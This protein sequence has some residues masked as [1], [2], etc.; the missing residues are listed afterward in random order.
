MWEAEKQVT[1]LT[2][3]LAEFPVQADHQPVEMM[4]GSTRTA[5]ST[6]AT[7]AQVRAESKPALTTQ[8][9]QNQKKQVHQIGLAN[10]MQALEAEAAGEANKL[11]AQG[12][13]TLDTHRKKE[14]K[15]AGLCT[16]ERK[17]AGLSADST[18]DRKN[19]GLPSDPADP[20][21]MSA[22]LA[23]ATTECLT[24]I[25]MEAGRHTGNSEESTAAW[26]MKL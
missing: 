11:E 3:Q 10:P 8:A 14:R 13:P 6:S 2:E 5:Q 22:G 17:S 1:S 7:P 24:D 16:G 21:L 25:M 4:A 15:S 12:W 20:D 19:A 26:M 18:A 23:E 9:S